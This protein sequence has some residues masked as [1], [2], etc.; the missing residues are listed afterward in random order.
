MGN[1]E[2]L[3]ENTLTYETFAHNVYDALLWIKHKD[4]EILKRMMEQADKMYCN[5][6]K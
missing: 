3:I 5:V 1:L 4:D 2:H 6:A